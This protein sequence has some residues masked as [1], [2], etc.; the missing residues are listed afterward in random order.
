[1]EREFVLAVMRSIARRD[2]ATPAEAILDLIELLART[3]ATMDNE[4]WE[5]IATAGGLLW[6]AE[7]GEVESA[8]Q[9]E[10]LMRRLRG[11]Q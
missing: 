5:V 1:M 10:M 8:G 11:Q 7:M 6:R 4:D 9:F 3:H 2:E